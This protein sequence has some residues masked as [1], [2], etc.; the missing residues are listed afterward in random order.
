MKSR[1]TEV[2]IIRLTVTLDTAKNAVGVCA[3]RD[4]GAATVYE[5]RAKFVGDGTSNTNKLREV[6]AESCKQVELRADPILG[7]EALKAAFGAKRWPPSSR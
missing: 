6:V 1:H 3:K 7:A 5:W 2:H 4:S